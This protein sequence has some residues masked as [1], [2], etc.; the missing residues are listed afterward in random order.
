MCF[1]GKCSCCVCNGKMCLMW[2]PGHSHELD[3]M[4]QR[5]LALDDE[6]LKEQSTPGPLPEHD[7]MA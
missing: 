4:E 1:P 6:F 5:L 7:D 2:H 3:A